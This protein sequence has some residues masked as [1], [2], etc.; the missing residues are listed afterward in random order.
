M[1]T[2]TDINLGD[3]TVIFL[4]EIGNNC[5]RRMVGATERF[6]FFELGEW[7][8]FLRWFGRRLNQG[9]ELAPDWVAHVIFPG[10]KYH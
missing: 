3:E 1:L 5:R 6:H 2:T 10:G 9:I 8:R 7:T 4:I